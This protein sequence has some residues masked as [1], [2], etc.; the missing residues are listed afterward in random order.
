MV[1]AVVKAFKKKTSSSMGSDHFNGRATMM[2]LQSI[3][4]GFNGV[5][6]CSELLAQNINLILISRPFTFHFVN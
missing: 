5:A 3:H 1:K 2:S 4:T 6:L